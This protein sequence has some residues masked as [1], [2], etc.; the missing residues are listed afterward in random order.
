MQ[1]NFNQLYSQVKDK[2]KESEESRKKQSSNFE[3]EWELCQQPRKI[4]KELELSDSD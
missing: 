1:S 2:L 3:K 4:Y